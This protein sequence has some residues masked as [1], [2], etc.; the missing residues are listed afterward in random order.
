MPPFNYT[1]SVAA[2]SLPNGLSLNTATGEISGAPKGGAKTYN[3]TVEVTDG[4]VTADRALSIAIS[5]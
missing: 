2:G 1:W 5:R 4:F 3:F